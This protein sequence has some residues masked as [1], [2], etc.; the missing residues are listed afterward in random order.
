MLIWT[1]KD[2]WVYEDELFYGIY[3]TLTILSIF[4]IILVSYKYY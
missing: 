4:V 2:T 1:E 3:I